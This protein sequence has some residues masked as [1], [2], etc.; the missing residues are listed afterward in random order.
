MHV[1]EL[2]LF[3][4]AGFR[5]VPFA[6]SFSFGGSANGDGI[7][8]IYQLPLRLHSLIYGLCTNADE[9][10][11]TKL[12]TVRIRNMDPSD[13]D[14]IPI[15]YGHG[16]EEYYDAFVS[17][18]RGLFNTRD[19]AEHTQKRK[20]VS[21]TFSARSI[22]QFE[23]YIHANLEEFGRDV[24]EVRKS[25]DCPPTYAP[26]I[27]VL[28]RRGEVSAT[29]GIFP[30]L[31]PWAK[32]L[33]DRFFRGGL[34]AVEEL[35]GIA[36]AR[37]S[38]R[39]QPEVMANNTPVDLLARLMEGRDENGAKLGQEELTAEA[40]TQLI[41]GSDTTSNT[42]CAIL[43]WVLKTR[44]VKEKLQQIL[45]EV[46]PADVEVPSYAVVKDIEYLSW[47]ISETMRIYRTSSL[48][49]PTT[50][51][52]SQPRFL[53]RNRPFRPG[54]HDTSLNQHM[55]T[56]SEMEL[57]CMAVTVFK[58]FDFEVRQDGPLET[59]EGFLRKPLELHVGL[60]RRQP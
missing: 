19:R 58:N 2:L 28:N 43:Y 15:I 49:L 39:L 7:F 37:V 47:V 25:S 14:A 55:G 4:A 32:F 16:N 33:P 53:S 45:A 1:E 57:Q 17:I 48:G 18:L 29:L 54:L 31:K 40:L 22:G 60:K 36:V 5:K 56:R 23:Q 51:E 24:A 52:N 20:T 34:E 21:H 3:N 27:Q 46:I 9:V 30:D 59:R 44:G 10:G 42:A 11:G 38:E 41:A 50:S 12:W 6:D 35:A 13:P 26:A 8:M